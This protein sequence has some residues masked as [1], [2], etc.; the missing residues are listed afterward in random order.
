MINN[1]P[2]DIDDELPTGEDNWDTMMKY[3]DAEFVIDKTK[4]MVL[5]SSGVKLSIPPEE[6]HMMRPG[7]GKWELF[8]YKKGNYIVL[9]KKKHQFKNPKRESYFFPISRFCQ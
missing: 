3:A 1:A 7:E 2:I 5:A 6:K 9:C 8:P 4:C